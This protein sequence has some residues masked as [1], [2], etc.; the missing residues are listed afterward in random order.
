LHFS[1]LQCLLRT[2]Q[3][4]L[5]LMS[6]TSGHIFGE[7]LSTPPPMHTTTSLVIGWFMSP[8]NGCGSLHIRT[9]TNSKIGSV[10]KNYCNEETWCLLIIHACDV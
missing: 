3:A 7:L 6:Q 9:R 2:S 5:V 10:P 4:W 8:S 1:S